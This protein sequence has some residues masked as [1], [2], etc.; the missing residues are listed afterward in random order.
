MPISHQELQTIAFTLG[1]EKSPLLHFKSGFVDGEHQL[2]AVFSECEEVIN[3]GWG[4]QMDNVKKLNDLMGCTPSDKHSYQVSTKSTKHIDG[5]VSWG[6]EIRNKHGDLVDN[7][8][9]VFTEEEAAEAAVN[10]MVT[11]IIAEFK[12]DT[13]DLDKCSACGCTDIVAE[14]ANVEGATV[15]QTCFCTECHTEWTNIYELSKQA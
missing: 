15:N 10:R 8:S 6:W 14:S 12:G 2:I 9:G 4:C 3:T 7:S 13:I 1:N 5:E 11:S